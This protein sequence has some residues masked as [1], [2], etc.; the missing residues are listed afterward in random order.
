MMIKWKKG[1][2]K[3]ALNP[4]YWMNRGDSG[5]RS[6]YVGGPFT[7]YKM[8]DQSW[9]L[10]HNPSG[11]QIRLCNTL[12]QA[13]ETAARLMSNKLGVDFSLKYPFENMDG[14]LPRKCKRLANGDFDFE[15][16]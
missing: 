2:F 16:V 15:R 1:T 8:S 3:I 9:N 5:D 11:L 13:K 10:S 6:G 4:N 14:D 12:R 7:I